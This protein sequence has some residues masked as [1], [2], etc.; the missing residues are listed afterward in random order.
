VEFLL[1]PVDVMACCRKA[2]SP[3]FKASLRMAKTL[4]ISARETQ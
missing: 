1:Q 4:L 2:S 3:R